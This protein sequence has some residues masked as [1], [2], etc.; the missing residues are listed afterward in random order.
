MNVKTLSLGMLGTNC[1]VLSNGKEVLIID[2][3]AEAEVIFHA[4]EEIGLPV[5]GILLTHAHYDHIGALDA[6]HEKYGVDVHM[7][8]DEREWI[9]DPE[10]N[11]SAK[12]ASMGI[13]PIKSDISPVILSEGPYSIGSFNFEILHTPGHSPGSLSFYLRDEQKVFSGDVLFNGGVGRTDL[14]EG[15][16]DVLRRSIK[17][18]LFRLEDDTVVYPGHGMETSVKNEKAT[19][20]YIY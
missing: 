17:D 13:E 8:R 16:F 1:Y 14:L 3:A 4:V 15:S 18:K 9:R 19:N 12:R 5:S 2:P 10:L 7:D 11:M 6:V 20:P